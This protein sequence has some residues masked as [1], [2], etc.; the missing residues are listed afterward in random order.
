M[1]G[2]VTCVRCKQAWTDKEG[3]ICPWLCLAC[4]GEVTNN[5]VTPRAGDKHD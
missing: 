4:K 3:I 5:E 1:D 2:M